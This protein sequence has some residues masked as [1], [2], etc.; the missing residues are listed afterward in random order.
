V[1]ERSR[2]PVFA[3]VY[4]G[5]SAQESEAQ[6]A[7]RREL[8]AAFS[9][10]VLELG[11]GDGRNFPL[12]PAS[13]NEVIAVE[14]EPYLRRRA[15]DRLA[16]APAPI[17]LIDAVADELPFEDNSFDVA[18]VSLVLCS[19]PDQASALAELRRVLRPGGEL[20]FY[21]HVGAEE[22]VLRVVLS[23]LDRSGVYPR[24]AGGCHPAR[25]TLGA[26]QTAGFEVD[27]CRRFGLKLGGLQPTIPHILGVAR[28]PAETTE[29]D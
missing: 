29:L 10:R 4:A 6:L 12:Y 14:P 22:G 9:G 11:A 18:V 8:L 13:V 16:R 2:H 1:S 21:E 26:I 25:D 27:R 3:R 19:V 7:C 5:S 28:R 15:T 20:R 23:V 17:R 24:L